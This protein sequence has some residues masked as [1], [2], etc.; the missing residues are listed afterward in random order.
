MRIGILSAIGNTPLVPLTRIFSDSGINL[1]AKLESLNPG[2]SIKDRAAITILEKAI[3]AGQVGPG[4][5]IIESNSGNMGI[6]LAQACSC[7]RLKFICVV[8]PKAT[9]QNLSLLRA[10]G[11]EVD[12]VSE[13][14]PVSGEYLP[15]RISRVQSL[16]RTIKNSFWPNQYANR[17]N[18][19]AHHITAREILR[20]L[21][22]KVDFLFCATSTCGTLRGCAEYISDKR[23]G[24][25]IVAVDAIGS[26]IFSNRKAK[27]LI[28]GHGAAVIPALFS[29]N[30]AHEFV[31]VSD[32]DCIVGCRRLAREEGI[33]VGGSSGGVLM[34]FETIM[35]RI[36][37][38]ANCA[39]I[40]ADRGER[41]LDTI[42]SDAWVNQHF[43]DIP[44]L[45]SSPPSPPA[46]EIDSMPVNEVPA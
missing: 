16:A 6:G 2:G 20:A 1:F 35:T 18:A 36:H 38:G 37:R 8:D 3:E 14:D 17:F 41:Y 15:A 12:M 30:L 19:A 42:Y 23:L 32:V 10:Y 7:Y 40:F 33:L 44:H 27:R 26:I 11:A 29:E 31:H 24:T 9:A 39:L 34:A 21:D 22:E 5:T 43:G 4:T 25:R 13:P 45:W 46:Q 28:P